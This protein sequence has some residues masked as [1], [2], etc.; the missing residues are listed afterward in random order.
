LGDVLVVVWEWI[1]LKTEGTDPHF[2]PNIDLAAEVSALH[3][4]EEE[5]SDAWTG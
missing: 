5:K 3:H 2:P 4:G 1:A